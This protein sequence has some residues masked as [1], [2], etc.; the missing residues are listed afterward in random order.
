MRLDVYRDDRYLGGYHIGSAPDVRIGR[1]RR[2]AVILPHETVSRH[3]ANLVR[4][5]SR[6]L[7]M[8]RS[9]NGTFVDGKQADKILLEAGSHFSIGPFLLRLEEGSEEMPLWA[10][11]TERMERFE[12]TWALPGIIGSSSIMARL[13]E[14]IRKVA[15]TGATVLVMGETGTGKELVAKAVHDLSARAH[16]PFVAINCGAISPELVETELFG[17]VKGAFTG[18]EAERKGAFQQ[19]DGGTLFLD[20][21]GELSLS[22]Q[23]KLLR[24]L[25][26]G[27]ARKVG[28]QKTDQVNVRVIA[29]THRDLKIEADKG[30]FRF[31]LLYRL[32]VLPLLVPPLRNRKEDIEDLVS[33][34]LQGRGALTPPAMDRLKKHP[35][36]GNVRELKNVL[37]R[38]QILTGGGDIT[39][40]DLVFLDESERMPAEGI[41]RLPENFEELERLFYTRALEKS[42]GNVRAAARSLGIPKSTL[43]DRLKRYGLYPGEEEDK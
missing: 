5:G 36:P 11:A 3:H 26:S 7:L 39:P 33:F 40:K 9:T 38:A 2:N 41:D 20:E 16:A 19:A 13:C 31:D 8:D 29:A 17:H 30:N 6:Y 12:K 15:E 27:E 10:K 21:I 34:F 1:D 28:A 32:H 14:M 24:V 37:E 42:S 22:L 25:E 23:P 4:Q 35:W 43:Y 18:A